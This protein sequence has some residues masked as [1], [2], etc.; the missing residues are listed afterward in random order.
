MLSIN[1]SICGIVSFF[2]PPDLEELEDWM[3]N[4]IDYCV[5]VLSH[6]V[7]SQFTRTDVYLLIEILFQ[8]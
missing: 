6:K 8:S 7:C 5:E 2:V 3:S 1:V 4:A